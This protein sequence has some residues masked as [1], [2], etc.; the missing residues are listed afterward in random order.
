[1]F[2]VSL[3]MVGSENL[4]SEQF[5][6]EVML[7]NLFSISL[8][9]SDCQEPDSFLHI[10]NAIGFGCHQISAKGISSDPLTT[11]KKQT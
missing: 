8:G 7:R 4:A 9:R 1:M 11:L 2:F 10:H 5:N 6:Q 3:S